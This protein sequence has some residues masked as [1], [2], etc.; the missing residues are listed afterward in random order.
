MRLADLRRYAMGLPEVTEEP[1]FNFGSFRVRGRIFVTLPPG[2]EYIH[3]FVP[4]ELREQ[5]LALHPDWAGKLMWGAKAVG[6]RVRVKA[7][8]A[9]A[10]KHYVL[11]AWTCKAPKGLGGKR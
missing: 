7:A 9:A 2:D 5:A 4:E 11:A 6:I 1:H 3:V 10:L 8:P